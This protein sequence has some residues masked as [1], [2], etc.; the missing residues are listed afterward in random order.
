MTREEFPKGTTREL[1]RHNC[2]GRAC[3]YPCIFVWSHPC[4][5][6][7]RMDSRFAEWLDDESYSLKSFGGER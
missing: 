3:P 1:K 7:S 6:E 2:K 5:I 4:E